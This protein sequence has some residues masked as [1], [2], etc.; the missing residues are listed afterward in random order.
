MADMI[1]FHW[2]C[3]KNLKTEIEKNIGQIVWDEQIW[4]LLYI[5]L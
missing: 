4:S 1:L 5:T 3:V 2:K